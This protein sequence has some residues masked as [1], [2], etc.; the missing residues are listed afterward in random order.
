MQIYVSFFSIKSSLSMKLAATL[1]FMAFHPYI[2]I[3]IKPLKKYL[4]DSLY[5]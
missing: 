5:P 2:A 3:K 4:R 1:S